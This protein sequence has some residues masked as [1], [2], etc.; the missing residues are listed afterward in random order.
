MDIF[1]HDC[2]MCS[3]KTRD[4][5]V[6]VCCFGYLCVYKSL[7]TQKIWFPS[8]QRKEVRKNLI[9]IGVFVLIYFLE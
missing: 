7:P 3:L 4:A 2:G 9:E 5:R 1:E 6:I 8:L